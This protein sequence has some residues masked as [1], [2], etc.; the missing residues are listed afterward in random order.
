MS[1]MGLF[2]YD[3]ANAQAAK[4]PPASS[5]TNLINGLISST[6]LKHA[7]GV[8]AGDAVHAHIDYPRDGGGLVDGPYGDLHAPFA[9]GGDFGGSKCLVVRRPDLAAGALHARRI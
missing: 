6:P 7:V 8:V 9:R 1:L 2:G 3:C 4:T 5:D